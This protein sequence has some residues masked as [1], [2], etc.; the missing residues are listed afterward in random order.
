MYPS[1]VP[2]EV[3]SDNIW[4]GKHFPRFFIPPAAGELGVNHGVANRSMAD[5]ILHKAEVCAGVEQVRGNRVLEGMEV[6]LALRNIG[7][8][9]VVLHEFIQSAAANRGV[10]ARE[11]HGGRVAVALFQVSFDGFEFIGLQRVQSGQGIFEAVNPQAV[12][13]EVKIGKAQHPDFGSSEAVAVSQEK[14]GIVPLGRNDIQQAPHFVLRQEV[15][16]GCRPAWAC[17]A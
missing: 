8:L 12:L 2:H 14:E 17:G 7:A 10:I 4:T 15:D 9:A 5:P 16:A 6:P 13:L 11:E 3:A 1:V